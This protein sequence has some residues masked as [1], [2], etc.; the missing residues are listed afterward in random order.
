VNS[1]IETDLKEK[2]PADVFVPYSKMQSAEKNIT[3]LIKLI[4]DNKDKIGAV[5]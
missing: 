1:A 4:E 3:E 2:L 5:E